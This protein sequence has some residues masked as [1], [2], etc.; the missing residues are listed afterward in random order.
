MNKFALN[1]AASHESIKEK[2]AKNIAASALAAQEE[3]IREIEGEIREYENQL[4]D[5]EDLNTDSTTSLSPAKGDFDSAKW[6]KEMQEV[7]IELLNKT[8][9]LT[10]AK[11]TFAEY[12]SE[13]K[14]AEESVTEK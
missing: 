2:R 10:V 7:K 1:L 9:E 3:L 6:V 13:V 12:F 4:M 5:L 14:E 8:V 11:E